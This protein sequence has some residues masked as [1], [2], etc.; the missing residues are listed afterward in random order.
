[1]LLAY[2]AVGVDVGRCR[3]GCSAL[4]SSSNNSPHAPKNRPSADPRLAPRSRAR[5][6]RITTEKK[7]ILYA[8]PFDSLKF[9]QPLCH[10]FGWVLRIQST[11]QRGDGQRPAKPRDPEFLSAGTNK[12]KQCHQSS[13]A[14]PRAIGI[15]TQRARGK[16]VG[17]INGVTKQ[18][19]RPA[20]Y[21]RLWR[22]F[23]SIE[24]RECLR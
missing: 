18:P 9:P 6:G 10:G 7:S 12:R 13:R 23:L 4:L 20:S 1:M 16:E 2:T 14:L 5:G 19:P 8:P 22:S 3:F 24:K 17:T 21:K 11:R 15:A